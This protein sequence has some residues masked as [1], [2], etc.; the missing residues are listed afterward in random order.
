MSVREKK[1]KTACVAKRI[2][3][4]ISQSTNSHE[5]RDPLASEGNKNP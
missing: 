3:S 4:K 5:V 2:K 1:K